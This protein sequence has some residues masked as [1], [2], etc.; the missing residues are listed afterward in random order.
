MRK[1][2]KYSYD[3]KTEYIIKQLGRTKKKKYEMYVVNRIINLIDDF[4]IKFVTQQYIS[5][6]ERYALVDLYFPQFNICVE[7]DE[8]HHNHK[9]NVKNDKIREA[10]IINATGFDKP[11]HVKIAENNIDGINKQIDIIV[12]KVKNLKLTTKDFKA[13]DIDKEF[14]PQ[15]YI[16][17]GYIDIKDNVAFHNISDACNCFGHNYIGYQRGGAKHKI[18]KDILIWFPKLYENDE[19]DNSISSDESKITEKH[20]SN[21]YIEHV[22]DFIK[23]KDKYPSKRIVFAR[24]KD[25]LGNVLYRFRG[26][27]KFDSINSSLDAGRIWNRIDTR[28]DTVPTSA[29]VHYS[30]DRRK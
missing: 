12:E 3:L 16:D 29:K 13:W 10:D 26:V 18:D 4:D 6:S 15:T 14:N 28:V 11:L 7:I 23:N 25:T 20:K 22:K 5:R 21:K 9:D 19:W 2:E 24:V 8:P 17:L 27:Y 1:D 30:R